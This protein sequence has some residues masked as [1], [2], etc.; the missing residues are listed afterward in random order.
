MVEA[1]ILYDVPQAPGHAGLRIGGG[2][3]EPRDAG[4]D[5]GARAVGARLQGCVQGA[6][7]QAPVTEAP[8]RGANGHRFGMRRGVAILDSA[9]VGFREKRATADDHRADRHFSTKTTGLG[10][11]K[12]PRHPGTVVPQVGRGVG[13]AAQCAVAG[14]VDGSGPTR[15]YSPA[16][17]PIRT[18]EAGSSTRAGTRSAE[19]G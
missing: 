7:G 17:R 4:Q 10:Q 12:G 15:R 6:V 1:G 11:L 8:R 14:S 16:T 19:S 18:S 5:D 2:E 3:H 13:C 9:V